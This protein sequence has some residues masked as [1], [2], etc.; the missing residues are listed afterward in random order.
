MVRILANDGMEK[1]AIEALEEKG[2]EVL[3]DHLEGDEL[4]KQIKNIDCLVVRSA[5]KV[6]KDL[7]DIAASTGKLKLVIRGGVGIDNIDAAY[8]L[9]KGIKVNNTPNASS[10]SVAE[11]TF[12]HMLAV[13]RKIHL[14]NVTMRE[15]KWEKKKYEGTELYEKTLGLIGFGRIAKEVAKR[16]VAFGM[17]VIY[18]DICTTENT[19]KCICTTKESVL[20]ESDFISLHVPYKKGEPYV[21]GEKEFEIINNGAYIINCARGGVIDENALVKALDKGKIAGAALD[22]FEKEPPA[23]EAIIKNAKISLTPHIGAAT[24][25]A[26]GR[27]GEEIVSIVE[28]FFNEKN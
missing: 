24:I 9:E 11:M 28:D 20:R 16:A 4:L 3:K 1:G 19:E 27:I 2:Y 10:I 26:Q 25:E 14:S 18:Y 12:G 22:V 15:G 23:N 5:T 17:K 6:R 8:A 21:I 7:I 13:A